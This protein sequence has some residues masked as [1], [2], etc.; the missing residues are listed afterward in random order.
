[1]SGRH[2]HPRRAPQLRA[3]DQLLGQVHMPATELA[4]LMDAGWATGVKN[5][6]ARAQRWQAW[7][8]A[9]PRAVSTARTRH[10]ASRRERRRSGREEQASQATV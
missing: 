7:L 3:G 5:T 8:A 9:N 4:A 2:R 1:M 10:Q 6:A